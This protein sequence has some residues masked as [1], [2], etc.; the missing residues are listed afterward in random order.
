M[1]NDKFELKLL[2]ICWR[3]TDKAESDFDLCAHG[4]VRVQIGD[5][6]IE[7]EDVT[8]SAG[9]FM[10]M[11]SLKENHSAQ[12][13]GEYNDNG[14]QLIPLNGF[15]FLIP[16]NYSDKKFNVKV[17]FG[18]PH[19]KTDWSV[20]H[21]RLQ[22]RVCLTTE[23]GTSVIVSKKHYKKQ[24]IDFADQVERFF[25]N[26]RPRRFGMLD[27][28]SKLGDEKPGYELFWKNWRQM[29]NR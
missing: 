22:G 20:K 6:I 7:E 10:L 14:P 29:R 4:H 24:I 16:D 3:T 17:N 2:S 15:N 21:L 13:V 18:G 11:R 27:G 26:S 8:V 1:E 5:E 23:N 9:A 25:K 12:A 28:L 19:V